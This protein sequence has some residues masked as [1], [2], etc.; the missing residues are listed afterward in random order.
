[1]KRAY[2]RLEAQSLRP[3]LEAIA[4]EI[5][6]RTAAIE[7]LTRAPRRSGNKGLDPRSQAETTAQLAH[8]KRELR[9][10]IE[11]LESLGCTVDPAEPLTVLVPGPD[12][13]LE[14][15]FELYLGE[16]AVKR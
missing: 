1:V 5:E 14:N 7:R 12:G 6:E 13:S 11:E 3:L 2:E 15:G 4:R 10:A 9:H 16:A 8:H